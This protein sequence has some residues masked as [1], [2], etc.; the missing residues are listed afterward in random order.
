MIPRRIGN[1]IRRLHQR[2]HRA[3]ALNSA[4]VI[5]HWVTTTTPPGYL[6]DVET[7]GAGAV[8]APHSLEITALV[9]YVNIQTTGY[10]R[11]ASIKTGD[12]I[13]D[14]L[15]DAPLDGKPGLR[16]EIGGIMHVQKDA[17]GDDLAASWDVR[18]NGVP[19][20]RTLVVQPLS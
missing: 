9:H 6:P 1:Q 3:G 19:I 11:F 18:C 4:P 14:F 8:V 15:G 13:L 5:L 10:V 7:S 17:G 12:V 2:I 16:F 20:T